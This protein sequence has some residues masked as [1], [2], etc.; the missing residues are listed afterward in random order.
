[1]SLLDSVQP[2]VNT[3]EEAIGGF[4]A[5]INHEDQ[6]MRETQNELIPITSDNPRG[7]KEISRV[8]PKSTIQPVETHAQ[9][10]EFPTRDETT[11]EG[12]AKTQPMMAMVL[13]MRTEV[14]DNVGRA[15]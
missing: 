7:S 10:I 5:S 8:L 12:S 4:I 11:Q 15:A 3:P 6:Q 1:M 2:N 13:R 9:V 14:V